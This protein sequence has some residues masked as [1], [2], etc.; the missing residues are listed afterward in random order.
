MAL[1]EAAVCAVEGARGVITLRPAVDA[2][3]ETIFRVLTAVADE[4][5]VR[6]D[7]DKRQAT[8]REIIRGC[9]ADGLSTV[10]TLANGT[11]VGFLLCQRARKKQE[12]GQ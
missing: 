5:L 2:N 10:A 1:H 9:Y 8:M 6:L 3:T 7:G 12:R 11:I 4:I